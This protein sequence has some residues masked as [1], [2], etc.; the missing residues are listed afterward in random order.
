[1][2]SLC[3]YLGAGHGDAL[4]AELPVAL[5]ADGHVGELAGVVVG[6]NAAESQLAAQLGLGVTAGRREGTERSTEVMASTPQKVNLYHNSLV[7]LEL[8]PQ[9]TGSGRTSTTTQPIPVELYVI[10]YRFR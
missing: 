2:T 4:H 5:A 10:T 3:T 1:M 7:P 9:L 6:I 8:L